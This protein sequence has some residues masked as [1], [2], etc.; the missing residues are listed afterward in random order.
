[1]SGIV[2]VLVLIP[3]VVLLA[4]AGL[5]LV[6]KVVPPE[7]LTRH[8][9]VAGYV[10]AVIGVLYAVILAQVVIAAWEQYQD[11]RDMAVREAYAVLNLDRLSR[12]WPEQEREA[13]RTVLF[14]YAEEVVQ[15]EWPAMAQGIYNQSPHSAMLRQLWETYDSIGRGAQGASAT[16]A[17]SLDQLDN[18]DEARRNRMLLAVSNLPQTMTMT[19]LVGA[20]VTVGFSYLFA[21]ESGWL[22]G[23]MTASLAVLVALLLLL[24]FQLSTPFQGIDS[25]EPTAMQGVLAEMQAVAD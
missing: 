24:E 13:V 22:H 18:L 10:Y 25:I 9:D 12:S 23:L 6:R 8:T 2:L 15:I 5:V 19:L 4:L 14:A 20:V 11:A 7:R 21:V 3:V 1:M 16:Y 17:T